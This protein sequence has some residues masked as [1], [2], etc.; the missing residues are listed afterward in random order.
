MRFFSRTAFVIAALAA[1]SACS[2][3]ADNEPTPPTTVDDGTDGSDDNDDAVPSDDE[4]SGSPDSGDDEGDGGTGGTDDTD[5]GDE[6]DSGKP[7]IPAEECEALG[8]AE[9]ASNVTLDADCYYVTGDVTAE[10]KV[11]IEPGVS[12]YLDDKATLYFK[13][14]LVANGTDSA[15]IRFL[16]ADA[17]KPFGTVKV[18]EVSSVQYVEFKGGGVD[19]EAMFDFNMFGT[20]DTVTASHL[21]FDDGHGTACFRLAGPAYGTV[22]VEDLTFTGCSGTTYTLGVDP[23]M[24]KYLTAE[25]DY[26]TSPKFLIPGFTVYE[27]LTFKD[28]GVLYI[29]KGGLNVRGGD[30]TVEPGVEIQVDSMDFLELTPQPSSSNYWFHAVGT[31]DKPIVFKAGPGGKWRGLKITSGKSQFEYVTID[32]AKDTGSGDPAAN[33]TVD[34]GGTGN[35]TKSILSNSDGY[36]LFKKSNGTLNASSN[37]FINNK[38]GDELRN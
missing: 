13:K 24:L 20:S 10:G 36:G 21:V 9:L 38:L 18:E 3:D 22:N 7:F 11:T 15:K 4:D 25:N 5:G 30:L 16:A 28:M 2:N 6:P 12:V 29:I 37:T 26:G 32:G 1:I 17:A 27:A 31:E 35:I 23:E 34:G 19:A 33:F 8:D 14:G